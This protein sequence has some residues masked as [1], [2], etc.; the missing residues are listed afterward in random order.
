MRVLIFMLV[1]ITAFGVTA[2]TK[3][4]KVVNK[5]GT[6]SFSDEPI[7]GGEEVQLS[8]NSTTIE[9]VPVPLQPAT[10]QE[11]P[12]QVNYRISILS[13]AP[14]ATLRNNNGDI[15]IASRIEPKTTGTYLLDFGGQQ[16]SS[17]TGVFSLE[18]ID[19][20]AHTY[21]VLFTDNKGKVIASS[22][23]RT[24]YL[25]QASVLIPNNNN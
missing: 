3:I 23:E 21:K 13:P 1:L 4:Y 7:A 18:N 9:S 16:Q 22:D 5:D 11:P 20:G 8:G 17:N 19:R 25:H 14:E 24:L 15:R 6:I 2:Q 12:K 10:P